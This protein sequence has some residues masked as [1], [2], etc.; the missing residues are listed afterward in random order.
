VETKGLT[1]FIL[2]WVEK[3][4]ATAACQIMPN[5]F[6]QQQFM[7]EEHIARKKMK[8]LGKG[9]TNGI[10][11]KRFAPTDEL[12]SKGLQLRKETDTTEE[13]WIWIFVGRIVTDK[14]IMELLDAFSEINKLYP[15][16]RLWL[17]GDEEPELDPLKPEYSKLLKS[18]PAIRWWGYQ[19]DI[20]PFLAASQ[21][22]TFPSYRE[23]FPNVPLQ[24]G[25]M[26]CFLI[27][28]DINGCNEIV[29]H[30][31][32]GLLV[33]P[34]NTTQLFEAMKCVRNGSVD[35]TAFSSKMLNKIKQG[36]DQQALWNLLLEE[37]RCWLKKKRIE[38]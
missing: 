8:V 14:G 16:D 20:R 18:H 29:D 5:S 13:A 19:N 17:L 36:F 24:A 30:Q 22:L 4:T 11:T 27:L 1:R 15:D 28:S 10:D 37:Y 3:L 12:I 38:K 35:R 33:P 21:V 7:L 31:K 32:D 23:G 2:K 25:A 9:S 6:V 26:G 34:K